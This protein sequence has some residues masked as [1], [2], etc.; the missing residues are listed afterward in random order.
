MSDIFKVRPPIDDN[1]RLRKA[2]K[3]LYDRVEEV[4]AQR[5]GP[6]ISPAHTEEILY[7]VERSQAVMGEMK[8]LLEKIE[9]ELRK[10]LGQEVDG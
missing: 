4:V 3:E 6:I 10:D 2:V 9:K 1:I 7:D 5:R 8:F